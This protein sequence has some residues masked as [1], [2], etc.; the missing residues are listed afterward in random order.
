MDCSTECELP[1][2]LS[3]LVLAIPLVGVVILSLSTEEE[4]EAEDAVAPSQG[5]HQTCRIGLVKWG[6]QLPGPYLYIIPW[7]LWA[8]HMPPPWT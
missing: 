8:T 2:C 7:L 6:L 3:C 1:N 5:A 4:A